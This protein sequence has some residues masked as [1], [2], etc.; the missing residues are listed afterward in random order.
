M[1]SSLRWTRE[2]GSMH[3]LGTLDALSVTKELFTRC[4]RWLPC[5]DY[6]CVPS[7]HFQ[8]FHTLCQINTKRKCVP[9]VGTKYFNYKIF[10]IVQST[11]H[12]KP[13]LVPPIV[14]LLAEKRL[15]ILQV[16]SISNSVVLTVKTGLALVRA[17]KKSPKDKGSY[18]HE[19]HRISGG[20]HVYTLRTA[21]FA[22]NN[23][24]G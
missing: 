16:V 10:L 15:C 2:L 19:P 5:I 12:S 22:G 4:L 11:C 18:K 7:C 23:K 24:S 20:M 17:G 9:A 3:G 21:S 1:Q 14:A 13:D 6:Q 8:R